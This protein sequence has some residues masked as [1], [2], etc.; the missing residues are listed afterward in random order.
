MRQE[1][2]PKQ[3][4]RLSFNLTDCNWRCG[5]LKFVDFLLIID[6]ENQRW[7]KIC[8]MLKIITIIECVDHKITEAS[9]CFLASNN[10]GSVSGC[11]EL[12][13]IVPL[14][15]DPVPHEWLIYNWKQNLW[16][17]I[18]TLGHTVKS[19]LDL[20]NFYEKSISTL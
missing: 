18:Y 13:W 20:Y 5:L 7:N 10:R 6:L 16:V 9:S 4:L 11:L 8:V 3:F 15:K 12:T 14:L 1:I 17:G 19:M 2:V